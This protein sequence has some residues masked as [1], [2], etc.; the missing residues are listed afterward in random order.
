M[1]ECRRYPLP[2]N[3][4]KRCICYWL[5]N[6]KMQDHGYVKKCYF[7][8]KWYDEAGVSIWVSGIRQL[9]CKNGFGFIWEN[10]GVENE[11]QFVSLFIQR[12]KDQ[13]LQNWHECV[14]LSAKLVSYI[15]FRIMYYHEL[16]LLHITNRKYRRVIS[17]F[18]ISAHDLEIECGR[19]SRIDRNDRICKLCSRTVENKLHF[20]LICII[21]KD[22]RRKYILIEYRRSPSIYKFNKLIYVSDKSTLFNLAVYLYHATERSKIIYNLQIN[23]ITGPG[24]SEMC[25]MPYANNKGADQPAHPRCLI[26]TFVVRCL[27]SIMPLVSISEISRL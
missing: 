12:L 1:A 14:R 26:S 7:M 13:Y 4:S 24:D 3:M 27:D 8:Q 2:I 17:H 20:V 23:V 9:L 18:R 16:Y 15:G 5:K 22:L 10:Q 19:F 21:Y 11:K 6:L 25:L